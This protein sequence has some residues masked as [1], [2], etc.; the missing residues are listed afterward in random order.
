MIFTA[1]SGAT[2]TMG[3]QSAVANN[4]ANVNTDGFR[5]EL[6]QAVAMQLGYE[7]TDIRS[8][9][10][11]AFEASVGSRFSAGPIIETGNPLD[12][13]IAGEGFFAVQFP[14]GTEAYTR[15][16]RFRTDA[17][18]VLVTAQGV[19]VAGDGGPLSVPPNLKVEIGSDGTLTGYGE[20]KDVRV[21]GK[22]KRVNPD[23]ALLMRGDDGLFRLPE[24][25][26]A[27]ADPRVKVAAGRIEGSNVNVADELVNMIALS[28][29]FEMQTKVIRSAEENDR[30]A[31]R[32]L[33]TS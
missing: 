21:L 16:G 32:L 9:R 28:R 22:L 31:A 5:A 10:A 19:P 3:R 11:H 33:S 2:Q 8:S 13:A 1:M 6:R 15:S 30:A 24:G 17:M 20:G 7:G 29:Q 23:P 12:V 14:D 25:E 26:M 18:G 27:D 4:L